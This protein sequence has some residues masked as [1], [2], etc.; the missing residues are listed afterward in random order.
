VIKHMIQYIGAYTRRHSG[1]TLGDHLVGT[2]ELLEGKGVPSYVA[3]AGGLHSIYGTVSFHDI[4]FPDNDELRAAIR[5]IVGH[6]TER[7][8]WL[9]CRAYRPAGIETG[10]LTDWQ[11]KE[12]LPVTAREIDDL[13]LIEAAN[14]IEQGSDLGRWPTIKRAWDS[15]NG[16]KV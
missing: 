1:R 9:F 4:I 10:K 7:L 5:D 12:P 14:L 16:E 2:F 13:R 8:I 11:S 6:D 15:Y 3:L